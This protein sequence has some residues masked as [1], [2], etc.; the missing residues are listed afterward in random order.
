[1]NFNRTNRKIR[2]LNYN[3][4]NLK[5]SQN[6]DEFETNFSAF[7]AS[8]RS[9]TLALQ[10][11]ADISFDKDGNIKR[12]G[13]IDGFAEWYNTKKKE[14]QKDPLC[15]YFKDI[16]DIDLHTGNT[17]INSS[18]TIKGPVT[19][20][21]P[22]NG[23]LVITTRGTYDIFN[24]GTAQELLIQKSLG[25]EEMFQIHL[26]NPPTEHKGISISDKSPI[27]L[28]NTYKNYLNNLTQEAK[29]LFINK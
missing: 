24:K 9:V 19:L 26:E 4:E 25:K 28:C 11:D 12:Y 14:M 16:R 5:N 7:I 20:S 21:A 10:T 23:M 3:F 29:E 1:M 22:Q 15:K 8:G 2:E 17:A 6:V 18:Y 27:N 13:N